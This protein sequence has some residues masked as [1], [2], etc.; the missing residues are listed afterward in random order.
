[1]YKDYV[2]GKGKDNK[3]RDIKNTRLSEIDYEEKKY[4]FSQGGA[5]VWR[6]K[7]EEEYELI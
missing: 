7:A 5:I 2:Y 1:M 6:S 3:M 4:L